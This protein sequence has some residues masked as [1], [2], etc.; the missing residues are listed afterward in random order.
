MRELQHGLFKRSGNHLRGIVALCFSFSFE[1]GTDSLCLQYHKARDSLKMVRDVRIT[2]LDKK[3]KPIGKNRIYEI[4]G[5]SRSARLKKRK[6]LKL[7]Y[8]SE[9]SREGSKREK[10]FIFCSFFSALYTCSWLQIRDWSRH[11][12]PD[13]SSKEF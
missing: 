5:S 7:S 6:Y 12:F 11:L 9:G 13:F 8:C 3:E 10:K 1:F 4:Q 2:F